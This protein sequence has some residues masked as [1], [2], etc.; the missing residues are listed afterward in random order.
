MFRLF[1]ESSKIRI[2]QQQV[3]RSN[4]PA[5]LTMDTKLYGSA[6]ILLRFQW[7][8]SLGWIAVN[9]SH[10]LMRQ[11][12]LLPRDA[13]LRCELQTSAAAASSRFRALVAPMI[14]EATPLA[15]CQAMA[16]PLERCV[17]LPFSVRGQ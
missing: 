11:V 7:Q 5:L 4:L 3:I 15:R 13:L 9:G 10:G 2:I 6:L 17:A 8:H 16:G 14:G 1:R 12:G